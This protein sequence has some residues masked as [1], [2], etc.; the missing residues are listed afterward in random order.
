MACQR[1]LARLAFAGLRFEVQRVFARFIRE[2]SYRLTVWRPGWRTLH[3]ARRASEIANVALVRGRREDFAVRLKDRAHAG[4]GD[5]GFAN[6]ARHVLEMRPHFGEVG[7]HLDGYLVLLL[8]GDV[9]DMNLPEL[10]VDDGARPGGGVFDVL[11]R[12]F[13]ELIHLLAARIVLEQRYRPVAVGEEIDFV[14]DPHRVEIVR[15]RARDFFR[16]QIR[17]IHHPDVA[18]APPAVSLPRNEVV[19]VGGELPAVQRL[20]GHAFHIRRIGSSEGHGKRQ[21][22]G[23]AAF[24]GNR[25]ELR[26]ARVAFAIRAE[27]DSLAVRRPAHHR[28]RVGM[29]RNA[30]GNT[31]RGRQGEDIGV[32]IVLARESDGLAIR[33]EGRGAFLAGAGGEPRGYAALA[34]DRPQIARIRKDDL[35]LVH[36]RLLQQMDSARRTEHSG[37]EEKREWNPILHTRTSGCSVY[38][39]GW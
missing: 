36:G 3:D 4:G 31:A 9:V 15:I 33:R 1:D 26:I 37:G 22:L 38:H 16:F 8:R 34:V 32:A 12:V 11:P 39:R 23:Q 24:R 6:L 35:C 19:T 14:A 29:E 27:E 21:S 5:P 30:F 2:V 13:D 7:R 18:G 10:F 17:E 28:V 25:E 20:V